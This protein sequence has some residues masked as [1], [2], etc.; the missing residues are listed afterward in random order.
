MKSLLVDLR[1]AFRRLAKA[2]GFTVVVLLTLALGIGVNTSMYTLV[3]VLF[4]RTVPFP[5][6]DRLVAIQGTNA[7]TK[8]DSFSFIETEEMRAQSTGP[9]RAF[10]SFT[11]YGYWSDTLVLPNRPAEQL[12][13]IDA[14]ADFFTTFGV[15]PVLGR[16]YTAEEEVPG[17]NRVV[18]LGYHVWQTRFGGDR[19]V[20]GRS[21]RLNAEQVTI[22]GVMPPTFT[23]PLFFGPVDIWRPITIPQHMINDRFNRYFNVIGRLNPGVTSEQAKAQLDPVAA[24]WAKDHPQD[25]KG[26]GFNLLP[27]HR[28]A[29]DETS[30]FIVLLLFGIAGAVLVVACANIANLQLARATAHI[31][32]LAVRSAL[33]ASRGQLIAHQLTEALV[34]SLGGGVLGLLL[35]LGVNRVFGDSIRL[36][37]SGANTLALPLNGRVL[38]VALGVS[39]LTGILFGLAP[40]WLASRGGVNS[41][42][43]QQTRATTS[44]RGAGLLRNGLIV[45]QVAVALA[46]LGVAGVMIRGLDGLLAREKGWDTQHLLMANIHLPEQSTYASDDKRRVAI[47]MLARRIAEIPGAEHTAVCSTAPLFG[48][49]KQ[50]PIQIEGQTSDDPA[51]QPIAGYTLIASDYF[52]TL[53]I[54][55]REGRLFPAEMKADSPRMVIINETMAKHFWP[56]TS[57]IGKRVGEHDGDKVVWLEVIGVVADIQYALNITDPAT[58]FQMYLPL[59]HEPWGYLW[60]LA[61]A[62]APASLKNE[63]RQAVSEFDPDVA[64]QELFTVPEAADRYQHNLVVINRTLAGFALLGLILAAVG[65]YGVVSY[66]VAQR[67]TEFGIRVALGATPR[68]VLRLVMS[69][70][71]MLTTAGLVIGLGGGYALNRFVATMIPRMVGSNLLALTTTAAVLFV[72]AAVACL[73]PAQRA[74]RVN[75]VEALRAE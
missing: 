13:S 56:N 5:D 52:A 69:R 12:Q 2:P 8:H 23:A 10:A 71:L 34:L 37:D 41:I 33:G 30:T 17:R 49:S 58:K 35:A 3:D 55:L 59:V 29:M 45:S 38:L 9:G 4:F 50:A 31:R 46:L 66:L 75:A 28:A 70:G 22:I 25:S 47:E 68:D 73:I 48:Y 51:K 19:D 15:Q 63:M 20:I 40:A 32:D 74:T 54:P 26:R 53:G 14:T 1:C 62:E 72:I 42:M 57:A 39:L 18:I 67:T 36:G 65:L 27:P 7:Q 43:K 6:A 16:A 24:N 64:V 61:K 60:L 21:I 44:G 11:A